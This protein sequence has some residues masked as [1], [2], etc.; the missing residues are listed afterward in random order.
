MISFVVQARSGSSR[1]PNKIL[2]PFYNGKSILDLLI[3]KLKRVDNT[4]VI[5]A[6]SVNPNSLSS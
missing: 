3:E 6:T 2:L 5:I 1:M 4:E